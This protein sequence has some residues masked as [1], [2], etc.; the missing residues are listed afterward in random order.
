MA[1]TINDNLS[2]RAPKILDDRYGPYTSTTHAN[3]SISADYRVVG[4]TVGVLSGTTTFSSGRYV[5]ATDGVYEYWYYTGITDNDLVL[6]TSPEYGIFNVRNYGAIGD[7]VA[8][9][10][11]A[12]YAA[13]GDLISSSSGI[14]YFPKGTYR[15]T[16]PIGVQGSNIDILGDGKGISIIKSTLSPFIQFPIYIITNSSNINVS[17]ISICSDTP[18]PSRTTYPSLSGLYITNSTDI[19]IN[20]VEVFDTTVGI[21]LDGST[22]C[23]VSFNFVHDTSADGIATFGYNK[24]NKNIDVTNNIIYNTGDDG[25]SCNTYLISG[26]NQNESIRILNNSISNIHATGVGIYGSKD[27][28]ISNNV[29]DTT[30]GASVKI[31]AGMGFNSVD[32]ILISDNL[33]INASQGTT[34]GDTVDVYAC[35]IFIQHLESAY[36]INNV[37]IINNSIKTPMGAYVAVNST[38]VTKCNNLTILSNNLI[39]GNTPTVPITGGTYEKFFVSNDGIFVNKVTDIS[40]ANNNIYSITGSPINLG[41]NNQGRIYINGNRLDNYASDSYNTFPYETTTASTVTPEINQVTT[42]YGTTST[43]TLPLPG[44]SYD[45]KF[46]GIENM[47]SGDITVNSTGGSNIWVT[48]AVSTTTVS[49]GSTFKFVCRKVGSNY[50]WF[51]NGMKS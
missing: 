11:Q 46:I 26:A 3:Q 33:S 25:I 38:D 43:W 35:G 19:N 27:V 24:G 36:T 44:I 12:I 4:L 6:K 9:D 51:K 30:F 18:I 15:I 42:F 47:G 13:T 29:I 37:S 22:G 8:D 10:T 40:I 41:V 48:S 34:G 21:Q 7:G 2:P 50:Y 31:T 28:I 39:G 5:S 1:I 45:S 49:A 20:N 32:N 23:T 14:L 16:Q 17:N